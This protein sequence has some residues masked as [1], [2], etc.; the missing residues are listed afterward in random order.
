MAIRSTGET[1]EE[2]FHELIDA[3]TL[4]NCYPGEIVIAEGAQGD[5]FYVLSRGVVEVYESSEFRGRLYPGT[6]FGEIALL[7]GCPRTATVRAASSACEDETMEKGSCGSGGSSS[8]GGGGGAGGAAAGGCELWFMDR[9]AFRAI[10]ARHKRKRLNMK[11]MLLEKVRW[12]L[13]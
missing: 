6:G 8:R 2:Q 1:D 4:R 7:Y 13:R 10:M 3:F 12:L 9:R 5:G 11:L